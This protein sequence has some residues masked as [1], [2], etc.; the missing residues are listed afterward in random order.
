MSRLI[1]SLEH[2]GLVQRAVDPNDRRVVRVRAMPQGK[3]VL[4]ERRE[5]RTSWS[6]HREIGVSERTVPAI[7][8]TPDKRLQYRETTIQVEV[9]ESLDFRPPK[10]KDRFRGLDVRRFPV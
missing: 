4:D 2:E 7:T 10:N 3:R 8:N 6:G 5:R 1:T 9:S